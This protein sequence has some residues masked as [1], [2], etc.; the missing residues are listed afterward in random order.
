LQI[1]F[2]E[3]QIPEDASQGYRQVRDAWRRLLYTGCENKWL[4]QGGRVELLSEYGFFLAKIATVV[5]AI[6]V[7]AVLIVNLTQRKRQRGELRITR[8]SEQYTEM[9]EE[10]S[11]ALLDA[12]QQK[13]WHKAQKKKY[14][15]DAKA[16]KQ[17]AK[18]E[19]RPEAAKPRVYVLDFKGSMDA[20]EV[21]SLR[22]EITAVLAVA[23]P[24]DQV[25]LR[26]ESPGGVVHGYG[27]ASS[28]LQRLRDKKIP[29]TVAV[30]K[31]AASGGYMMA[32]V[33]DRIVAAPFSIIGS[34]GVVAQIPNFN[35]FLKNK[36]IDVELHTAGQY[37]RT[38]TLLGENTEEGRQKFREDL[39]DTHQLFKSFVQQMRPS[40]DI[41]QVATGEHWYG[42]QALDKGLVDQVGT[43]DDLLL[44]LM[45][46]RELVGVRYTRRKKLMDRFTNSAA[47]S[48]DRL[49]LRWLQRGQKPLL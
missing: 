24:E 49:L 3:I 8:L 48:A 9:Q 26:L 10:M 37:K 18:L 2:R 38:L 25:V 5:I 45:E 33:A 6:A 34:I 35:R 39:N 44:G 21:T 23:R 31:V 43:S 4:N 40:L 29:L 47:E 30:D 20:H 36:D 12:H 22:E 16:A 14:K 32:C 28:Q 17:K 19:Q 46:G 1:F 15:L 13:L 41:E 11:V 7:I 27:L 42:T